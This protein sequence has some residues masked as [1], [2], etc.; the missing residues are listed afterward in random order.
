MRARLGDAVY[1][2]DERPLEAHVVEAL[3]AAGLTLAVA[4]SC[5]AGLVAA[6]VAEIPGASDV[7]VGGVVA[8]ADT[9]KRALLGV[10]DE[11]LATHGAVSAE[12]AAAMAA[13]ARRATGADVAVAVTGIA[14]PGGGSAAKPVGLVHLHVSSPSGELPHR[15]QLPGGRDEVREWAATLALQLVR[16]AVAQRD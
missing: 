1:A 2:E 3:R 8:Y 7:L 16:T 15:A 9:V 14:G 4:E 5:T 11:L 10:P 12:C 6:R 13:G